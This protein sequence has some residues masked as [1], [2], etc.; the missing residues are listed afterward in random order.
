MG[1]LRHWLLQPIIVRIKHKL[2]PI[3]VQIQVRNRQRTLSETVWKLHCFWQWDYRRWRFL[4]HS[5]C[6]CMLSPVQ[7]FATP[8]SVVCQAPL[9]RDSPGKNNG[10]GCHALLLGNFLTQGLNPSL[11][12]LLHWQADFLLLSHL[13]SPKIWLGF[14]TSSPTEVL[15]Q[16]IPQKTGW[17]PDPQMCFHRE[18]EEACFQRPGCCGGERWEDPSPISA[19]RE[20]HFSFWGEEGSVESGRWVSPTYF[21]PGNGE[22]VESW[23][24]GAPLPSLT[25]HEEVLQEGL[26]VE[27]GLRRKWEA[28][29]PKSE[30]KWKGSHHVTRQRAEKA[31]VWDSES[32]VQ[33]L[34]NFSKV[35]RRCRN[36]LISLGLPSASIKHL[37]WAWWSELMVEGLD[38]LSIILGNRNNWCH[39]QDMGDWGIHASD[40]L[41]AGPPSSTP[42]PTFLPSLPTSPTSSSINSAPE[43]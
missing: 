3:W 43:L 40:K 26:F 12:C 25:P 21:Y 24:V 34:P 8:W 14:W 33:I 11:Q 37:S 6:I 9:S 23:G 28:V 27:L 19:A 4:R 29:F 20:S 35:V 41:V 42:L 5:C 13:G 32:G 18:A 7:L 10:A 16:T 36:C 17:S 2:L 39:A 15:G 22:K 1:K 31:P 38:W 30:G